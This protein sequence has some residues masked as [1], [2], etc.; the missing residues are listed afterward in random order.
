MAYVNKQWF[1]AVEYQNGPVVKAL[2][3]GFFTISWWTGDNRPEG[4]SRFMFDWNRD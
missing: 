3:L 2:L 4:H 1:W